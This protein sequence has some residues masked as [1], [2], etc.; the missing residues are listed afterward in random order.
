MKICHATQGGRSYSGYVCLFLLVSIRKCGNW[1]EATSQFWIDNDD[2]LAEVSSWHGAGNVKSLLAAGTNEEGFTDVRCTTPPPPHR[3]AIGGVEIM[4]TTYVIV[5][6]IRKISV[7]VSSRSRNTAPRK[8]A[9]A[10]IWG[11]SGSKFYR[12]FTPLALI[13]V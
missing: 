7:V 5:S 3:I 12:R 8:F 9:V 4:R 13:A 2:E 11:R 1:R 10:I 6:A